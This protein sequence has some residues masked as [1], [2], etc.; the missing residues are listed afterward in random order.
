[1]VV[2]DIYIILYLPT[3]FPTDRVV[4]PAPIPAT[5]RFEQRP[6]S[7]QV[8]V[9]VERFFLKQYTYNKAIYALGQRKTRFLITQP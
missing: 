6:S 2:L 4:F 1:M 7:V 3:A 9:C 8:M 5:I